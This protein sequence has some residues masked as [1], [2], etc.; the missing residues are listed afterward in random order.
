[1]RLSP[2][3]VAFWKNTVVHLEGVADLSVYEKRRQEIEYPAGGIGRDE[4]EARPDEASAQNEVRKQG[5]GLFV[6]SE[7]RRYLLTARHVVTDEAA[8]R[9]AVRRLARNTGAGI[10][11]WVFPYV[12]RVPTLDEAH[13][14][15]A[16]VI[17]LVNVGSSAGSPSGHITYS[18]PEI[19]LAVFS[20]DHRAKSPQRRFADEL[21]AI[22]HRPIGIDAVADGP[23][24]EGSE[25]FAVGYPD[26]IA[27]Y[28]QGETPKRPSRGSD[29]ASAPVF[30]FGHVAMVS[31]RLEYFWADISIYPGNS[32]GPVVEG[33]RL[34]GVVTAQARVEDVRV[35]FAR[36]I[37]GA[38]IKKLL[39]RQREKDERF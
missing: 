32:G 36:V 7:G 24:Q 9:T 33:D 21:E 22:G 8:A 39:Q 25:I 17:D 2:A 28:W 19:D 30:S 35:P 13:E 4:A 37:P 10:L 27:T 31:A 38:E 26:E 34:V 1:V 12:Y 3:Q 15:R 18:S 5:T 14:G 6:A 20:L 16:S 11:N 23:S 29:W